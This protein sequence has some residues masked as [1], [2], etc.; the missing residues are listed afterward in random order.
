MG[1]QGVIEIISWGWGTS[2]WIL[3]NTMLPHID[4][5]SDGI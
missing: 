2:C 4:D 5:F 3:E 1:P